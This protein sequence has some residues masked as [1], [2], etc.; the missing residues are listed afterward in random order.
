MSNNGIRKDAY[1]F[2]AGMLGFGEDEKIYD[3]LPYFGGTVGSFTKAL[4]KEGYEAHALSFS[5]LGSAWDR[6]CEVSASITG[7]QVDY[8]VAHSKKYGHERF[9]KV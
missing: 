4:A 3:L 8:G 2:C 5:G 7:T 6:A 1:A 9:G